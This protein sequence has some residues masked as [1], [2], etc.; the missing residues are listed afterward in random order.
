M[1]QA[2]VGWTTHCNVDALAGASGADEN[3]G[4]LVGDEQLH[5]CHVAHRVLSG[6]N[7]LVELHVFAEGGRSL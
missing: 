3:C 1:T 5:Q 6:N 7:D 4:L 2:Y